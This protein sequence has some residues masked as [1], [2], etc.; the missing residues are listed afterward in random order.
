MRKILTIA[1]KDI[2][3]T[4]TDRS[5]LVI[6]ILTPLL[7][8]SIIGLAFG[9]ASGGQVSFT[10][11]PLAI[12]NLD[13]GTTSNT[14]PFVYGELF[15]DIITDN[16]DSIVETSD[17]DTSQCDTSDTTDDAPQDITLGELFA[18]TQLDDAD[19]ART[20]VQNGEYVAAI[21]IPSDFTTNLSPSFGQSGGD[22]AGTTVEVYGYEGSP[23]SANIVRSVATGIV[24]Q[25]AVGSTTIAITIGDLVQRSQ[26]DIRL[27]IPVIASG[28][29]GDANFNF[30]CAFV[31]TTGTIDI[32]RTSVDFDEG[33]SQFVLVLIVIGSA[34]A[35]FSSLFTAQFGILSIYNEQQGGTL[36]R[37]I[38]TP[39]TR[40]E[41][42]FGKVAGVV[43]TV[44]FQLVLLILALTLV[45]TVV[46]GE[47]L[48]IWGGYPIQLALTI[49]ALTLSVSGI[50]LLL[51]GIARTPEQARVIGPMLN[52]GLGALGGAFGFVLPDTISQFS[53][54][55]WA[56]DAFQM[57]AQGDPNVWLNIIVLTVQGGVMSLVGLFLFNQRAEL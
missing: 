50:G 32:D 30:N 22:I 15:V 16:A 26:D 48:F 54:I 3:L 20:A 45:A 40:T 29:T 21:I 12:V 13:E 37:L 52:V 47:L 57:M 25:F 24:E 56:R 7:L 31:P 5:L 55:Y 28:I 46:E 1:W 38:V 33:L 34:Q 53:N 2:Y 4:F 8:S 10:D 14:T 6:M 39:T 19:A 27:A 41:I 42:L 44:L 18:V 51:V 43:V 11:L 49:L 23:I 9:G 36:Q 17:T 35:I